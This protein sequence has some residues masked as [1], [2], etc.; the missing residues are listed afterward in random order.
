MGIAKRTSFPDPPPRSGIRKR[1]FSGRHLRAG[2]G[3]IIEGTVYAFMLPAYTDRTKIGGA[4]GRTPLER[5]AALQL[6][7]EPVVI[8]WHFRTDDR[9]GV[10]LLKNST[11]AA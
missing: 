9:Y 1:D 2:P 7:E 6:P 5:I 11:S 10:I 8:W 3:D 4:W